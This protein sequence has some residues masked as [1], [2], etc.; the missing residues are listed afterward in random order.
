MTIRRV[1]TMEQTVHKCGERGQERSMKSDKNV[2][3]N[4]DRLRKLGTNTE[5]AIH[6]QTF[7]SPDHHLAATFFSYDASRRN[8]SMSCFS[9]SVRNKF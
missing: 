2:R 5:S 1:P 9:S 3:S 4:R 6:F 8:Q 7:T